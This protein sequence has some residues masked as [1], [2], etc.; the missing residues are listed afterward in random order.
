[1]T[2]SVRVPGEAVTL[3]TRGAIAKFAQG[4]E[5]R[6]S[7]RSGARR[8]RRA[9]LAREPAI[10]AIATPARI[11]MSATLKIPVRSGPIPTFMKSITLP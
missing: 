2:F 5:I 9:H 6:L 7:P 10:A 3:E 4:L 11:A 1:M 8:N